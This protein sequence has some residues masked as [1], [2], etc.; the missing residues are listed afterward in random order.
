MASSIKRNSFISP[1]YEPE[2]YSDLPGYEWNDGF[3][4]KAYAKE[5][6]DY[7]RHV[8]QLLSRNIDNIWAHRNQTLDGKSGH[9]S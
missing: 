5:I 8:Y 2:G 6:D 7:N 4:V 1:T 3:K 9:C